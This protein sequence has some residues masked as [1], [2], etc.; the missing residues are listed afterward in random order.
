MFNVRADPAL[1]SRRLHFYQH[2]IRSIA[3]DLFLLAA[4]T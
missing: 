4:K 2:V 3:S 1:S